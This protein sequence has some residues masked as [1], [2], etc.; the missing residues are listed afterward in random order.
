MLYYF[1]EM[2]DE[3]ID[4]STVFALGVREGGVQ[5]VVHL[6]ELIT[7]SAPPCLKDIYTRLL[8]RLG[9]LLRIQT[10]RIPAFFP[11]SCQ[12]EHTGYTRPL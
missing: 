2:T 5:R 6:A 3:M 7:G 1:Y 4:M 10:T 11:C 8:L 12:E 9:E